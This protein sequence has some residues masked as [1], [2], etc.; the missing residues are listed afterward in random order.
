MPL[1]ITDNLEDVK[2]GV[3]NIKKYSKVTQCDKDFHCI[4]C[5]EDFLKKN[6]IYIRTMDCGHEYCLK[7]SDDWFKDNKKCPI[8]NKEFDYYDDEQDGKQS[9]DEDYTDIPPLE[10][11]PDVLPTRQ[12]SEAKL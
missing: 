12:A 5:I 8:C 7:C 6:K 4:I 11:S 9:Y 10:E 2:V 3:K 1:F